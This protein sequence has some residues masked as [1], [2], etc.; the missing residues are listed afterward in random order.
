MNL[1]QTP[2]P[3]TVEDLDYTAMSSALTT[4]LERRY[5]DALETA[6]F[7][8]EADDEPAVP[9]LRKVKVIGRH[10]GD[11]MLA[12]AAPHLLAACH[13]PG[14]DMVTAL[15]GDGAAHTLHYGL[16][17]R[18]GAGSAAS[19]LAGH[20]GA[21][22]AQFPGIQLELTRPLREGAHDALARFIANAPCLASLTGIPSSAALRLSRQ[23]M[24]QLISAMGDQRYAMMVVGEALPLTEV[25]IAM[26][27]CRHLLSELHPGISRSV[28][29]SHGRT[30]GRTLQR[31]T[32]AGRPGEDQVAS[33]LIR[34]MAYAAGVGAAQPMIAMAT[35]MMNPR[36]PSTVSAGESESVSRSTTDGFSHSLLN[37]DARHCSQLIEAHHERLAGAR[38]AGW[39][40]AGIYLAADNEAAL[41]CAAQA[42]RGALSGDGQQL[43]PIRIQ[44]PSVPTLRAAMQHG[45]LLGL[46]T[47]DDVGRHP[48]GPAHEA[49]ATCLSGDELA[50][51]IA[52]PR[53]EA[54]GIAIQERARFAQSLASIA[55][56]A[57]MLGRL[58]QAQGES[59]ASVDV[60][61]RSLNE[62]AL[63]V[64]TPGSGK[65][66]TCM[67]LLIEAHATMGVPFLVIEP[68]KTEYRRLLRQ[69]SLQG[70]LRVF[71]VGGD[72]G[73]PL[74]LNPLR[75]VPGMPLLGHI[76]LLKAVFNASFAMFAGMPQILEQALTEVYEARGW[77]LYSS[78][79]EALPAGPAPEGVDSL[80]P[81]LS[82]LAAQVE[83]VLRRR[84]YGDEV[85]RNIGAAL[86]SRLNGLCMGAKGLVL[87]TRRS[88]PLHDLFE[89][90]VVVELNNL[91]D[92]DEKSFVMALMLALLS[93]YCEAR[94]A[95]LPPHRRER[96]QHITL[97][98]EA[99][100]L[101]AS[102]P[103]QAAESADS[104][105]KGVSLFTD[106]LAELRAL[107]EGFIVAEQIPTKLA[108]DVLKNTNL[109]IIHRLTAPSDGAI[110]GD[111]ANLDRE[112]LR[113]LVRLPTGV[114]V[115][116]GLASNRGEL[117]A[118]AALV[119]V[120]P[121]KDA[122]LDEPEPLAD[123]ASQAPGRL[124]GC[125]S[126]AEPCSFFGPLRSEIRAGV[127]DSLFLPIAEA[128]LA[129]NLDAAAPRFDT[130]RKRLPRPAKLSAGEVHCLFVH[131]AERWLHRIFV[132]RGFETVDGRRPSAADL[133]AADRLTRAFGVFANVLLSPE[134]DS[135]AVHEA[136]LAVRQALQLEVTHAGATAERPGCETCPAR[137][138][139]LA[140]VAARADAPATLALAELAPRS[141]V[142][143]FSRE[144]S[145]DLRFDRLLA[146]LERSAGDD[147]DSLDGPVRSAFLYC[148]ATH[149]A[150]P[151]SL[152]DFHAALL[153]RL[154]ATVEPPLPP[155]QGHTIVA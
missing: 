59:T 16:R 47:R 74:R 109:K 133:L 79:N 116:H 53:G 130:W 121:V 5:L 19:A 42:L 63:V 151:P 6:R 18:A 113:E 85:R 114:A 110:L 4:V 54:P 118:E 27:A 61:A 112:Q 145:L 65:T 31:A 148:Q 32:T 97:I 105:G 58:R 89:R 80:L 98:E 69:P 13:T 36:N 29:A 11:E 28:S 93:Q 125:Q 141:A 50:T 10:A 119:T 140:Y 138:V 103:R 144:T 1:D 78:R 2:D 102:A 75:P 96:L 129:G 139:A 30:E 91:R 137:C 152:M 83:S 33:A 135:G 20:E 35:M 90:P 117:V 55:A 128:L 122:L 127:G 67:R 24:D 12:L 23:P 48:L 95:Q 111:S 81:T 15:F 84:D 154:R 87:D 49:L 149:L 94:Q 150:L 100:R 86:T 92:D 88:T 101:L 115:V 62:H 142:D 3:P 14:H 146:G 56:P 77:N 43:E 73:A 123:G 66:N 34:T 25:E 131:A 70:R 147:R 37:A 45:R 21:F 132:A 107:G 22:R 82:D 46:R 26:S 60:S 44:R 68:A 8:L 126:C 134:P 39:W 40:R 38:G 9:L 72:T 7:R 106:M 108:P 17:R 120:H 99:H 71:S 64:G 136:A 51:L 41:Q 52:P 153:E 124:G 143:P 155:S 57:L 104:R 76:D